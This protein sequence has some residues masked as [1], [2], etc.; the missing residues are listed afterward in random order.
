MCSNIILEVSS[1]FLPPDNISKISRESDFHHEV[2]WFLASVFMVP[3]CSSSAWSNS[4]SH[5]NLLI[6]QIS[7]SILYRVGGT[8]R[9]GEQ[10]SAPSY[11]SSSVRL[12]VWGGVTKNGKIRNN[13]QIRFDFPSS[14]DIW[15]ILSEGYPRHL[16]LCLGLSVSQF[17]SVFL[18]LAGATSLYETLCHDVC[19]YYYVC[20]CMYYVEGFPK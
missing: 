10:N 17:V 9:Q 18:F 4:P 13:V 14:K 2:I 7:Q 3:L 12:G 15:D 20:L 5:L 6:K 11:S 1:N 8:E 19:V 16:A